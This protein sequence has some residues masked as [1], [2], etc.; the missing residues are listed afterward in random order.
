MPLK[1][2]TIVDI[3]EEMVLL[4]KQHG[5]SMSE[6]A[7]QFGVSRPTVRLW[8]E[9]YRGEDRTTLEDR[10]H[11]TRRCPHR[12]AADLEEQIVAEFKACRFGAKKVRQRLLDR[13]PDCPWPS[14]RTFDAIFVRR[15]LSQPE[16]RHRQKGRTPF[17]RRYVASVPGELYTVD[18]KGQFRLGTG[19]YCYPITIMDHMSRFILLCKGQRQTT[20][21]NA[22]AAIDRALRDNGCPRALQTDNGTPFG[23]PGGGISSISVALM[24]RDIQPIFGRPAKPQDNGR[25]ERMHRELAR[26]T[27]RPAASDFGPQQRRLN[28]FVHDYNFERPHEGIAMRRPG[29]LFHGGVRPYPT[30]LRP[31]EYPG[32]WEPRLVNKIGQVKWFGHDVFVGLALAG[33]SVAFEPVADA[34]S[35][36]H[37]YRFELGKLDERTMKIF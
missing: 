17:A 16:R 33:E 15:G 11:A 19:A 26:S 1:E 25:H 24:K 27:A 2:R 9:R 30:R 31:P 34:V 18:Y 7:E 12:T 8:C 23:V 22:W 29:E 14:S 35:V 20:F 32:T 5:R 21:D 13:D 4:V 37:Y 3:R 10:S 6:V 36:V 28:R